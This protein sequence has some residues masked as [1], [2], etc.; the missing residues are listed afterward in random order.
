VDSNRPISHREISPPWVIVAGGF[1]HKGGMDKAN[2]ALAEYLLEQDIPVHLI[3]HGIESH[4]RNHPLATAYLI[5]RPAQSFLLGELALA[6]RAKIIIR[7][8]VRKSPLARVVVNGG[9]CIWPG[10]N[11]AHYIHHAWSGP[12]NSRLLY[13]I[14]NRI[15]ESWAEK[16]ERAA[17]HKAQLV[18]TNSKRTSREV[19]EYF[20]VDEGRVHTVY[21]GS[22]PAWG[23]VSREE[24]SASRRSLQV[25]ESRTLAAFVGGLGYDHRKGFDVLFRA[26][27]KLCAR[28]DWGVDLIVAGGGPATADWRR[29][30][31]QAGLSER[32]RLLG[33]SEQVKSLLAAADVLVSPVRYEAYGLNVQEAICRCVPAMVSAS[34]GVAERY[35]PAFAPMLF[36]NPEDVNDVVERLLAWHA[37]KA[38]WHARFQP[39]GHML[40]SRSWRDTA[41]DFVSIV[42][43]ETGAE[44][45]SACALAGHSNL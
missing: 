36:P 34:A 42:K 32:I 41:I 19:V 26:W 37:N 18:I 24:R 13:G 10:I 39:F 12:P 15:S 9:N 4:L 6:V 31:T 20:G 1:H 30:I 22:D 45:A 7:G 14:K 43:Q 29:K 38:E 8:I 28:P 3:S 17:F 23:P 33:F 27:E 2:L 40:R 35:A 21:L 11:W 16:S 44:T 5:P 25:T